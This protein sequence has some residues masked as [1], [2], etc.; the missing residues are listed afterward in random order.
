M[1]TTNNDKKRKTTTSS[2]APK[3]QNLMQQSPIPYTPYREP[4]PANQQLISQNTLPMPQPITPNSTQVINAG[5]I[6]TTPNIQQQ[7]QDQPSV[8][9][10]Q[11]LLK[12]IAEKRKARATKTKPENIHLIKPF[13]EI[14][15]CTNADLLF[16]NWSKDHI[17]EELVGIVCY[18]KRGLTSKNKWDRTDI[19][20]QVGKPDE[21]EKVAVFGW[22]AQAAVLEGAEL[23]K[24]CG[25]VREQGFTCGIELN[26]KKMSTTN[27]D[28]KRKTT[29]SSSAP[30]R[31]NLMQQ[32]PIP[33]TPYR[34]PRPANQQLIS[35]N[36]L[37][38]PQPITPNSTQV[39]NAG[40]IQTTP[41]IQQQQQDQP[42]VTEEQALLKEIAE[43]RKAR[44]TKTKPEN[45]HLIK[46]F[47]EI[48]KCTNADLLFLNWSKDH[49]FEE[50]VG[51]VCYVKRGLT[52]K[53]KW[54]RTDI[55]IQVGKPDEREKVAVFGW[56]AQAAVL[57]GAE[58]N[59]FI[60]LTNMIVVPED[61]GKR[62]TWNGSIEFK[63]KFTRSST[64]TI[65]EQGQSAVSEQNTNMIE[66][67]PS[68]SATIQNPH[69]G[70]VQNY[71]YA[72]NAT[73]AVE[74]DVE[75]VSIYKS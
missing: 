45:I 42:S 12:E 8:T 64:L 47:D 10:E 18:V 70:N 30:K 61:I 54:D 22:G 59:K 31:Q 38:M 14:S 73:S 23:N 52:S 16:L 26:L 50:L 34:E 21:R 1:S 24:L 39:I 63:L 19:L 74:R 67:G 4:R 36:T 32:S 7:Q 62:D 49:I 17:F 57:E 11:A 33:Y 48:S 2:S 60:R 25:M 58:L 6:Q 3:R 72:S 56:G 40:N 69:V 65:V 44:A 55:L 46:P 41:N 53:N 20:I 37:P 29:T 9:E 71:S 13:D 43:K 75:Y 28:K 66:E 15:K 51:I 68:T 35:Q 5:N 27:N